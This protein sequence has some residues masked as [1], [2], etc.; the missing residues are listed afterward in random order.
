VRLV[1]TISL[2]LAVPDA[3]AASAWYGSRTL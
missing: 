3:P 2:M 1:T